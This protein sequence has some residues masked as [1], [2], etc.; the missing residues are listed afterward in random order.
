MRNIAQLKDKA[1]ALEHREQ[2]REAL[3]VLRQVAEQAQGEEAEIGV[4]NRIGDLHLRVG[5]TE[6]AV[7]AYELAADAYA[8]AGLQNNA[9]ALC[10]KVLRLVPGRASVYLKLGQISAAK[11]F[12]ADARQ[13]FLEYAERMQRA[14][15]LDASW[16]ALREFAELSPDDTEVRRLLADQLRS[17]GRDAE[18]LEQLQHLRAHF[19]RRGMDDSARQLRDEILLLDP[20]ADPDRSPAPEP[21]R[22]AEPDE[23]SFDGGFALESQN[24]P[25]WAPAPPGLEATAVDS[26][27]A[28]ELGEISILDGL[29]PTSELDPIEAGDTAFT[30]D[31]PDGGELPLLAFS[32]DETFAEPGDRVPA[33]EVGETDEDA[34]PLPLLDLDSDWSGAAGPKADVAPVEDPLDAMRALAARGDY[35]GAVA[36]A[37]ALL[38][39][40][41]AELPVLQAQVEYAFRSRA[42]ELLVR[43]YLDLAHALVALGDPVR[44]RTVFQR[45]LKVDPGNAE[46]RAAVAPPRRLA[47]TEY[48]DLGAWIQEDEPREAS[49]RFVVDAE[50]PSGDEDRDFADMLSTFKQKVAEHIDVEDSSSHYDLGVAFMEMGLI[51]EAIAQ[52]QVA[53]RGGAPPLATLEVLGK[54]FVEKG[55]HAVATRVLERATRLPVASDAEL[56]CVLYELACAEERTGQHRA[57]LDHLE[58]VLAVDIRFRD[59]ASRAA[60]LRSAAF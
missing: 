6:R 11:G 41:P 13:S 30:D 59:A 25:E 46:A 45:V 48:V 49:T 22:D 53:L 7:E 35:A 57:A 2:W 18:A 60:S 51:D 15:Q 26:G 58:R 3:V 54:C 37:R 5:E 24:E 1:R 21:V 55:Q 56:V 34:E 39:Q 17:H 47:E 19:V 28:P 27:N 12:L 33:E 4:W 32:E 43:A 44:S 9:I 31:E 36:A 14:G 52:F 8:E 16:A 10:K 29:E 20:D 50:P 40:R 38:A 42:P 23:I